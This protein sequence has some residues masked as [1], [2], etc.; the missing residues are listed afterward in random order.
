MDWLPAALLRHVLASPHIGLAC[1]DPAGRILF[2]N[3]MIAGLLHLSNP[4]LEGRP[5]LELV[6][7]EDRSFCHDA[8]HELRHGLTPEVDLEL[9]LLVDGDGPAWVRV[10]A[11]R[12]DEA[13]V[14]PLIVTLLFE[15][16]EYAQIEE[17]LRARCARLAPA[18]GPEC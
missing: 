6:H 3:A 11:R 8:F 13:T 5:A 9:R 4:Q 14:A 18:P 12:D 7:P 10:T 2:A 17:D 15:T 1:L 16:T